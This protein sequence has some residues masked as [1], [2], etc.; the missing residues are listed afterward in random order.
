M[1]KVWVASL[2]AGL[3]SSSLLAHTALMSCVDNGDGTIG[4]E[5]GYSDGSSA[6]GV[7]LKVLQN[8]KTIYEVKFD[9]NSEAMFKKPQGDYTVLLDGGD[10]HA[11]T[12]K[13][14]Q[15]LK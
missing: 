11:L 14:S 13:S 10:G 4:C 6:S 12:I 5:A 8:G 15:I 9:A 1:K 2:L 3:V 7:P